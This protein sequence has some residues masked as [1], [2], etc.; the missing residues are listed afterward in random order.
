MLKVPV[1]AKKNKLKRLA[2][3]TSGGDAPGMNA[4]IRS[5]VRYGLYHDCEVFGISKGYSG[6]LE[7]K[8]KKLNASSVANILQRGGT[9]LKS[10]RCP[11]F[12]KSSNRKLANHILRD[13][14]IEALVVI[15]GNGS[16]HGAHLFQKENRFPTIGIPGTIDNDIPDCDESIGFDTAINTAL[17]AIDR[18]RDTASA[19]EHLFLVEVMGRSCGIIATQVG[20]SG[21]AETIVT[22][23]HQPSITEICKTINHGQSRGKMSS[24][25]VVSE[26]KTPGMAT[27]IANRLEKK[28]YHPRVCTLGHIQRGG[29]PSARDRYLA[30][31]LGASAISYLM[32]GKSHGMVAVEKNTIRFVPFKNII[33]R[34]KELPSEVISLSQILAT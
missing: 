28:G 32:S 18:I 33:K 8:L 7:E 20:M 13:Y 1:L 5:V 6:L 27:R 29:S 12:R 16:F 30:S 34:S 4:A 23:E 19:H 15:G 17:E 14:G 2:V 25:I 3:L 9:I 31:T 10:S 24:I 22:P 21:G 11:A 26:S